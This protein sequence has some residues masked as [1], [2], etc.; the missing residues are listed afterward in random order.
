MPNEKSKGFHESFGFAPIGIY[1]DVG[2]KFGKWY[3]VG[4]FEIQISNH[5][6]KPVNPRLITEICETNKLNKILDS[7]IKLVEVI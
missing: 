4:W 7:A 6:S 1:H 2:Y 5:T 3:D